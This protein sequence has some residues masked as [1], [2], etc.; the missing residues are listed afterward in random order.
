MRWKVEEYDNNISERSIRVV[1][2]DRE[3][4]CD[5]EPYYPASL[6][7]KHASLIA[8]AP[9]LLGA[10]RFILAFYVPGQTYLDTNAWKVAEASARRAVAKAEGEPASKAEAVA[11]AAA[12]GLLASLRAMVDWTNAALNCKDWHW[13]G[14][15]RQAAEQERDVAMAVIAKAEAAS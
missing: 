7:P 2:E 8:A 4:I 12:P 11:L 9:E 3:V 1:A 13:D 14:D 15:Q 6:N 10:L 5:N